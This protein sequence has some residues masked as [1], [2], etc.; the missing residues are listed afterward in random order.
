MVIDD[1]LPAGLEALNAAFETTSSIA[2]G[3]GSDRWW[4]SFNHFEI[5]DDKIVLFADYLT[6][7]EHVYT[8]L[9]RAT[10]PGTSVHPP[11]SAEEMYNPEVMGRSAGGTLVVVPGD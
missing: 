9:A 4:G 2:D 6:P 7:G 1:A 3:E 8:Y 11:I 5:H 10:T